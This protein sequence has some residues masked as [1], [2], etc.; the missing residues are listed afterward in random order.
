MKIKVSKPA[1]IDTSRVMRISA[2][3]YAEFT[4]LKDLYAKK[5]KQDKVTFDQFMSELLSV[6][7]LLITGNEL[8]RVDDKV[9]SDIAEARGASI[10][11][12]VKRGTTPSM[13]QIPV[14]VGTD[15]GIRIKQ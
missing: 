6:A 11:N 5:N 12:A 15:D 8:Y 1:K 9:F 10:I 7:K 2:I 14:R 4:E 13:P 3:N